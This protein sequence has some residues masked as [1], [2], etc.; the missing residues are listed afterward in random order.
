VA[1]VIGFV[2]NLTPLSVSLQAI[3]QGQADLPPLSRPVLGA[4]QYFRSASLSVEPTAFLCGLSLCQSAAVAIRQQRESAESWMNAAAQTEPRHRGLRHRLTAGQCC[5]LRC[6]WQQLC[7]SQRQSPLHT[8][9]ER[10]AIHRGGLVAAR[11]PGPGDRKLRRWP[12]PA[13]VR[14]GLTHALLHTFFERKSQWG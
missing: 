8:K 13:C 9:Q 2:F 11:R 6:W 7:C 3:G 1:A 12:C 4:G 5:C 14:S 10:M